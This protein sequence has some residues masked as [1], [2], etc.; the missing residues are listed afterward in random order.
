MPLQ[1]NLIDFHRFKRSPS[2]LSSPPRRTPSPL[3]SRSESPPSPVTS[4]SLIRPVPTTPS[5]ISSSVPSYLD[6]LAS[7]KAFYEARGGAPGL[8]PP[9]SPSSSS[10]QLPPSLLTGLPPGLHPMLTASL[11]HHSPPPSLEN[12]RAGDPLKHLLGGLG[13]R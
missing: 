13:G 1:S 5:S 4:T 3:Y 9:P 11:H 8:Q 10:L 6:Q 12:F 2:P 7:L